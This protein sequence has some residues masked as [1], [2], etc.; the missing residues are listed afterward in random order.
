[1]DDAGP[2]RH[3]G[4]AV[5][6]LVHQRAL[7]ELAVAA[8]EVA[9]VGGDDEQ[10]VL[11]GA[12][13]VE[14]GDE[15]ADQF[16]VHRHRAEVGGDGGGPVLPGPALD[17]EVLQAATVGAGLAGEVVLPVGPGRDRGRVVHRPPR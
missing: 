7:V 3:K 14:R 17:A 12:A 2:A 13:G 8:A 16:V 6:L 10:R 9:V 11:G 4:D 5:D 15:A 1:R